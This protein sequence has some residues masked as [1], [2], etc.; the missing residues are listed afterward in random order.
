MI[1]RNDSFKRGL[2]DLRGSGR[3]NIEVEV[4]AFDAVVENLVQQCNILLQAN[5][6][7]DLIEMLLADSRAELRIV[8]QQVGEFGPLLDQIE[9]RH[10][11]RFAFELRRRNP[12]QL[13]EDIA[14]VVE[15]Q[16]AVKITGKQIAFYR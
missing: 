4:I 14:G 5:A 6:F 13:A 11:S 10:A 7:A 1:G 12:Q 2:N 15:T 8:Q 16:G 9:F 3:K